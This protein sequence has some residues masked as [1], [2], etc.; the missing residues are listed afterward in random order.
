MMD[1][2]EIQKHI[3]QVVHEQN[4]QPKPEFEGYSPFEMHQILHFTFGQ[5]SP[6]SMQRL[7][8]REYQNIP[9][10]NQVK[11]LAGLIDQ[12]GGIKLTAKGFLPTKIVADIYRQGFLEDAHIA[13]GIS[14][15]YRE[16]DSMTVNLTRNLL[17]ISGLARKRKGTLILTKAAK[18][19][20][21]DDHELLRLIF[22]T[23]ASRFNWA[24]YD[25]YGENQIGQLGYGFSLILLSR[26]GQE[27]KPDTF[28]AEKYF[29][30]Y[31]LLLEDVEVRY[32]TLERYSSRCY[33]LRTFERFL[34]YFGL[35][36]I[37]EEGKG[38]DSI[39]FVKK[40]ELFDRLFTFSPHRK[41]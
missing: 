11:Y 29:K 6:V 35:V 30:A 25:G 31:P 37:E 39:H 8:E 10:L 5:D 27:R 32:G 40:T 21:S 36:R 22:T 2:N 13:S 16:A 17:E 14:R 12:A 24:Y 4:N 1:L 38:L 7:T 19:P 23:F 20:L 9:M 41:R 33:S 3:D 28:Y 34:D 18:R 26:Y 15:L